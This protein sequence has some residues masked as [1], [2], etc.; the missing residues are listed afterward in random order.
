MNF[1]A[2]ISNHPY[3][4]GISLSF[5]IGHWPSFWHSMWNNSTRI[6]VYFFF[7]SVLEYFN[8]WISLRIGERI[9][10][11]YHV[12]ETEFSTIHTARCLK[13]MSAGKT[14]ACIVTEYNAGLVNAN[15]K[16]MILL[17]FL[18][19]SRHHIKSQ[20]SLKFN[21]SSIKELETAMGMNFDIHCA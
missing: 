4:G 15:D 9:T 6:S 13:K 20:G 19:E 17:S 16:I 7:L 12:L 18:T 8:S 1:T 3:R 21:I 5:N 10:K 2:I 14:H 11:R